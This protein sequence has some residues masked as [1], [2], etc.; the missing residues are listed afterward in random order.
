MK[1]LTKNIGSSLRVSKSLESL[2]FPSRRS[3]VSTFTNL[4]RVFPSLSKDGGGREVKSSES[5]AVDRGRPDN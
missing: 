5:N 1:Q 3:M 2:M 4:D